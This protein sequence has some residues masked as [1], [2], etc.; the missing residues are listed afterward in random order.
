MESPDPL[1]SFVIDPQLLDDYANRQSEA[2]GK[3]SAIIT[4]K[5]H[6]SLPLSIHNYANR[7][8]ARQKWDSLAVAARTL[9]TERRTGKVV[10]RSFSKFFNYHEK[11]AYKPTGYEYAF[12]IEEKI[13]GSIISL[14]CYQNQWLMVSRSSFD[15]PHTVS[16][17]KI[18]NEKYPRV[19]DQLD[20]NKT[21]VFELVDP[22]MPIKIVYKSTDLILLSVVTKDGKEPSHDFDWSSF[23]FPRSRIHYAPTVNLAGL[24]RLNI[25]NEE[26][27][28]VKFWRT[29]HDEYPQRVKVKFESYLQTIGSS[30]IQSMPK[31]SI[32]PASG[33][34]S[35]AKILEI[36]LGHRSKIHHFKTA[37]IS[38]R[39]FAHRE[40]YL[41]SL[42]SIADDYGGEDWMSRIESIW[43]RID[44]LV[45]LQEAEWKELTGSLVREGYRANTVKGLSKSGGQAF[46]KRIRRTDIN[47]SYRNALLA[48]FNAESPMKQVELF[49]KNIDIPADLRSCEVI[50]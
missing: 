46:M 31:I 35:N 12:A 44:A 36:Y 38:E 39:M 41:Q 23:P 26:G 15:S 5:H 19:L 27:F 30:V 16:A 20:Q 50:L 14:F 3:S 1:K 42:E 43:N 29:P 40:N 33:P 8:F 4:T 17:L 10:S 48:W 37:L 24:S 6:P 7:A 32:N 25:A 13:D 49:V 2:T 21:Y 18:L 47:T 22:N 28:V 9:V 34:P 11:L 45:T